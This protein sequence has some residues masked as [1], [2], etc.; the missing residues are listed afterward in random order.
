MYLFLVYIIQEENFFS[1]VAATLI[2]WLQNVRK[3]DAMK[4]SLKKFLRFFKEVFVTLLLLKRK[5]V[6]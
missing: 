5:I 2:Q 3:K 4:K 6:F 1:T